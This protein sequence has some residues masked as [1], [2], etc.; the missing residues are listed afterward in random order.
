M[1]CRALRSTGKGELLDGEVSDLDARKVLCWFAVGDVRVRLC[2]TCNGFERLESTERWIYV[3]G[4][5][6]AIYLIRPCV[7]E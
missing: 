2:L 1:C 7:N 3:G 4:W 6:C 5:T